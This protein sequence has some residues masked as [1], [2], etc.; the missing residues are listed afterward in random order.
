L[1][2]Y[3]G[4]QFCPYCDKIPTLLPDRRDDDEIGRRLEERGP[5]KVMPGGGR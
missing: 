3:C 1:N 2:Y 5:L 4:L